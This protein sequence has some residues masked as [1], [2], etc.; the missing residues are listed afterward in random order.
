LLALAKELPPFLSNP[1]IKIKII[2]LAYT[3]KWW[4][5][6]GACGTYLIKDS[7]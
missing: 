2:L 5:F 1:P 7:A 6:F 3:M 4:V